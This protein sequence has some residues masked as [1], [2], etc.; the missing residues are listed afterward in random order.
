VVLD[1]I[2]Q[3]DLYMN[4]SPHFAKAF[5]FLRQK[6]LDKLK[7]GRHDIDG[8]NVYA[9]VIKGAGLDRSRAKLEVH[10]NYIDIQYL[11]S[12]CN[13]MGWKNYSTCRNSAGP[14]DPEKDFELLD[15]S[16]TAWITVCPGD[17]V[18][19]FPEDAHAPAAGDGEFHKVVV[20]VAV[21][22]KLRNV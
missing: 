16:S 5:A 2:T 22:A 6:G 1:Q 18:I 21:Q 8:D 11:I 17:F 19:F 13:D 7:E 3:A 15:D 14:Y 12:G 20:K 4:L 10:R 9:L